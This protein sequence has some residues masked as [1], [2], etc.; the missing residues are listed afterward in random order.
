[1][2]EKSPLKWLYQKPESQ[3]WGA[4]FHLT[5]SSSPSL[6]YF[7]LCLK[8]SVLGTKLRLSTYVA[9]CEEC[10]GPLQGCLILQ[11]KAWTA[12]T[13]ILTE[14]T[15]SPSKTPVTAIGPLEKALFMKWGIYNEQSNVLPARQTSENRHFRAVFCLTKR[16]CWAKGNLKITVQSFTFS[17]RCS[18]RESTP[19][20]QRTNWNLTLSVLHSSATSPALLFLANT[21][22]PSPYQ[23]GRSPVSNHDF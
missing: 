9:S 6:V 2:I 12:Q 14:Q 19:L 10:K 23:L 22:H 13:G 17:P 8:F 20:T 4:K 3:N 11:S 15:E 18:F 7:F 16:S 5:E 21:H 1:M